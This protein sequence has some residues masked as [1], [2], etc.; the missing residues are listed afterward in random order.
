MAELFG[1]DRTVITRHIKNIFKEGELDETLV[2]AKNAQ[3]KKYGRRENHIQLA[4]TI[5]YNLDVIISVFGL[6]RK[7]TYYT[8]QTAESA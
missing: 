5:F 8:P 2:C 3:P 7:T 6:W 4:E 1:R